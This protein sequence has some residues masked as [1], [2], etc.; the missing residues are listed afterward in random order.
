MV[1]DNSIFK[2]TP[3]VFATNPHPRVSSKYRFVS[4]IDIINE[5]EKR[6]FV[7]VSATQDK[8]KIDGILNYSGYGRHMVK[9]RNINNSDHY[10]GYVPELLI[11]NA[12]D[13]KN[14]F[15][16]YLGF[17][18]YSCSNG[19]VVGEIKNQLRFIHLIN[20]RQ[21]IHEKLLIMYSK[22][23]ES[24]ELIKTANTIRLT[25]REIIN[26]AKE[27][28]KIRFNMNKNI[29][30]TDLLLVR[31]PDDDND[32]LWSV[33]NRIQENIIKGGIPCTMTN[34]TQ[35]YRGATLPIKCIRKDITINIALWSLMI[36]YIKRR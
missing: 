31:R 10:S 2:Y 27:A 35:R 33:F 5:L 15:R 4:T 14:A 9:F 29:N 20:V 1:L 11:V 6:G 12:H 24:V 13:A 21:D 17:H 34:G 30:L 19:L 7:P 36:S 16:A 32:T 23:E 18:I 8:S 26:L 3:A 25:K 28:Y 22:V